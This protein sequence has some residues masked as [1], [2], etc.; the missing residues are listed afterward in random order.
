M[1]CT[2]QY[3]YTVHQACHVLSFTLVHHPLLSLL[4]PK[5]VAPP[6]IQPSW[7]TI[8]TPSN[9]QRR[10]KNTCRQNENKPHL[11]LQARMITPGS[12]VKRFWT[13]V[14]CSYDTVKFRIVSYRTERVPPMFD[15]WHPSSRVYYRRFTNQQVA[16]FSRACGL[17]P[18][19]S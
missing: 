8:S 14:V 17:L 13:Y 3:I 9:A 5:D 4:F 7:A 11:P 1:Y 16:G 6:I 19:G 12:R 15:N 2:V 18:A 10:Y